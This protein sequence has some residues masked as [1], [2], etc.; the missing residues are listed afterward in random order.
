M[1]NKPPLEINHYYTKV[2]PTL[3]QFT[4]DDVIKASAVPP[5]GPLGPLLLRLLRLAIRLRTVLRW[6]FFF[7][8][9]ALTAVEIAVLKLLVKR[10]PLVRSSR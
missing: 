3:R 4:P 5:R 2:K 9:L 1:P 7:G 8:L 10:P 6:P